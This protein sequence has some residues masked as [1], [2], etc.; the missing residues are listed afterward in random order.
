MKEPALN[1][2]S[3][4]LKDIVGET[5]TI[6]SRLPMNTGGSGGRTTWAT[7]AQISL[8]RAHRED[9]LTYCHLL[10]QAATACLATK[11]ENDSSELREKLV[12]LGA[13]ALSMIEAID[14]R[15]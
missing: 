7:I 12:R 4:I 2:Y 9:N 11:S 13:V 15:E 14:A 8:D 10:D 6:P 1:T 3:K 5:G